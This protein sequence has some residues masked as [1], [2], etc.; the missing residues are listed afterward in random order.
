M[1]SPARS[2]VTLT[3][4][5]IRA[6]FSR[7]KRILR[8]PGLDILLAK[9]LHPQG[10]IIVVT[11]R[12]VGNAP[13]RNKVRRRLKAIFYE[14]RLFEQPY[15]VIVIIK[16]DG[17]QLSYNSLVEFVLQAYARAYKEKTDGN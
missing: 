11:P 9:T 8:T 1:I 16:K 5:D 6:L 14:R 4:K 13:E 3:K 10:H 12:H 17:T 15:D 7:A 2:T